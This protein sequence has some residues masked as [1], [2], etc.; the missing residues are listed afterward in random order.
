MDVFTYVVGCEETGQGAVIDPGGEDERILQAAAEHGLELR[1]IINTHHHFDHTEGNDWLKERTGADIVMHEA[2]AT[3][4]GRPVDRMIREEGP[5]Q[6]GN[7]TFT[8]YHTPGHT[9]G[10]ICLHAEG[11]LF[12]GD[13][14]FVGDSGRTDLPGGHRPTLGASIR[15]L[16]QLPAETVVCPGHDYG[17]SQT[18][19]LDWEQRH[20]VNAREYGFLK[21]S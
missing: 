21:K 18:S 9:P 17:P 2:D 6:L 20:N 4:Y 11:T 3:L 1:Y 15:K 5:F 13:T 8:V 10:G 16:M 12:T 19:T 14:L 7:L